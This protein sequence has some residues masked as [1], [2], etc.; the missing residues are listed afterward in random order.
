MNTPRGEIAKGGSAGPDPTG[1][2][3]RAPSKQEAHGVEPPLGLVT[4]KMNQ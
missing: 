1:V 4:L 2:R 3:R